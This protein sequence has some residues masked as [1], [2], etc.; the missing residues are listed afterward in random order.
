MS[1]GNPHL[2]WNEAEQVFDVIPGM[3]P[4]PWQGDDGTATQCVDRGH[5]GCDE[6]AGLRVCA[7]DADGSY[8]PI[9]EETT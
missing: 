6:S 4:Y 1:K 7:R 8:K 5:C 2:I 3:C 9:S